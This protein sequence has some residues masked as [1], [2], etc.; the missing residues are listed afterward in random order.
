[1]KFRMSHRDWHEDA[2]RFLSVDIVVFVILSHQ[3]LEM[4]VEVEKQRTE[5]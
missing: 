2:Y 3:H 4:N 5:R 1:M